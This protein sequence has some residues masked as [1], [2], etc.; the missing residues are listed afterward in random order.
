M[1]PERYG[2]VKALLVAALDR[3]A[4]ERER[5][6]REAAGD[7]D[8]LR[9]EVA[10]LLAEDEAPVSV[11]D[12]G[13]V[14]REALAEALRRGA[15]GAGDELSPP[16]LLR[17]GADVEGGPAVGLAVKHFELV[18]ELGQG[19][20]G[21][22]FLARD[23]K[24]GRPVALKFLRLRGADHVRRF[25]SE[26]RATA[27]CQ[28]ENIV[29]IYEAS[30]AFG[31]PYLALEYLDGAPLGDRLAAGPVPA[32]EAVAI[33]LPVLRALARAHALGIVH[34]DLKP[35][36]LFLTRE[37]VVKVLDFG[38][39]KLFETAEPEPAEESP[40]GA[41][42]RSLTRHGQLVGTVPY[43]S[44][45]Q[46]GAGEVDHRTDLWAI[47]ILFW[48]ML[49]Q[50]HPVSRPHRARLREVL[51]RLDEPLPSLARVAPELD[52]RL[53]ALVDGCLAKRKEERIASAAELLAGLEALAPDARPAPTPAAPTTVAPG[54]TSGVVADRPWI[55]RVTPAQAWGA[56]F[57]VGWLLLGAALG[58]G[59]GTSYVASLN[60]GPNYIVLLPL[61]VAAAVRT[62]QSADHALGGLG[63]EGM[64]LDATGHFTSRNAAWAQWRRRLDGP[65]FL[66]VPV[67][68]GI[69]VSV[70][71]WW[72]RVTTRPVVGEWWTDAPGL[73]FAGSLAQG[74]VFVVMILFGLAMP[75][76][77]GALRDLSGE[78]GDV[79]LTYR[80]HAED[81]QGGFS[82]FRE[83]LV[84][85]LV[86]AVL[87]YAALWISAVESMAL[88]LGGSGGPVPLAELFADGGLFALGPAHYSTRMTALA[89]V[90]SLALLSLG[91]LMLHR[92]YWAAL[93]EHGPVG[94]D[95]PSPWL[96]PRHGQHEE[97]EHRVEAK[98]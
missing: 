23:T 43:M 98:P 16:S 81:G 11:V 90:C 4:A 83:P 8:A 87:L 94:T 91:A 57:V 93:R 3:P 66:G 26:A 49:V 74:L 76:F 53:V 75:S 71:E 24:L 21:Q 77:V 40:P 25:L 62:V 50:Q 55:L 2:Q 10:S 20:M 59:V 32:D 72:Q 45:E 97:P 13:L 46:W 1:T 44:P 60:W 82:R 9:R 7:D 34:R 27:R 38:I 56:M 37:G 95:T 88:E 80:E 79:R 84:G 15:A 5:F 64:L 78:G 35:D 12:A 31:R 36:N 30:E 58:L 69:G 48:H 96:L 85:M 42:G 17:P 73:G 52:P 14:P 29:V 86:V 41:P 6:V 63:A 70:A 39:A 18:R 67:A 92:V 19:G 54:P 68:G 65:F 22:V 47:G 33:V 51:T 61:L 89:L 28:H